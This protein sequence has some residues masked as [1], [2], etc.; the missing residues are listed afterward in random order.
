M[1]IDCCDERFGIESR[2]GHQLGTFFETEQHNA[3]QPVDV[4]E[5]QHANERLLERI[6]ETNQFHDNHKVS[7][8]NIRLEAVRFE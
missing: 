4:E 1:L 5:R 3:E 7:A 8:V 2:K 6:C